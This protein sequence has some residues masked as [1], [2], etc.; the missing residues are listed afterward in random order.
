MQTNFIK[1]NHPLY[2]TQTY[3]LEYIIDESEN[4]FNCVGYEYKLNKKNKTVA[5]TCLVWEYATEEE[6]LKFKEFLSSLPIIKH[7]ELID[8]VYNFSNY[9]NQEDMCS[10]GKECYY[11]AEKYLLKE[12]KNL[13]VESHAIVLKNKTW[14]LISNKDNY[15]I[16]FNFKEISEKMLEALKIFI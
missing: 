6:I 9:I 10:D 4:Y 11:I 2:P 1:L 3:H 5:N 12:L 7:S 15:G 8:D 13:H 14:Y 16:N